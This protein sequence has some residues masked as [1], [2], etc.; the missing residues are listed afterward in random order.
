MEAFF[1][2][3][4]VKPYRPKY[5][6]HESKFSAF[7]GWAQFPKAACPPI[8]GDEAYDLDTLKPPYAVQLVR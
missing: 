2:C 4:S 1:C 7:M 3:V 5:L 8:S 6:D